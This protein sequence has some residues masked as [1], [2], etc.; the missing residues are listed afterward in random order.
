MAETPAAGLP[1]GREMQLQFDGWDPRQVR[2]A[3]WLHTC[4]FWTQVDLAECRELPRMRLLTAAGEVLTGYR[5]FRQLVRSLRSLWPLALLT[6]VPGAAALGE[7]WFPSERT[8]PAREPASP[9]AP[10]PVTNDQIQDL[11]KG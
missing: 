11:A 9:P 7:H 8:P 10:P 4:D 2:L 6:Y 1:P 5:A 3:I